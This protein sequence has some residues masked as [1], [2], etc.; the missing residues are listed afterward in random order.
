MVKAILKDQ[1][2]RNV[3]TYVDDIVVASRKKNN[4]DTRSCGNLCKYA[5][6]TIEVEPGEMHF[7]REEGKVLGCLVSAKGIEAN[8]DKINVVVNMRPLESKKEVQTLTSRIATLN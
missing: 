3:F 7:W 1:M 2:Q 4:S 5:Q 8:L 6:G